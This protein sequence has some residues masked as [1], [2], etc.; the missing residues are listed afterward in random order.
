MTPRKALQFVPKFSGDVARQRASAVFG[1][2]FPL[3]HPSKRDNSSRNSPE[4]RCNPSRNPAGLA[5]LHSGQALTHSDRPLHNLQ[6]SPAFRLSIRTDHSE[7][8]SDAYRNAALAIT[9]TGSACTPSV[10]ISPKSA[11]KPCGCVR[12][13]RKVV[14]AVAAVR[15]DR[16]GWLR[17]NGHRCQDCFAANSAHRSHRASTAH[18]SPRD[19]RAS[20]PSGCGKPNPQLSPFAFSNVQYSQFRDQRRFQ[21]FP[22]LW[23]VF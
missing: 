23:P 18:G 10:Q 5:P 4:E 15:R 17:R 7:S 13:V 1:A 21:T 6:N 3:T 14:R 8:D 20:P 22:V 16:V 2:A 9:C 19:A 11:R 12:K